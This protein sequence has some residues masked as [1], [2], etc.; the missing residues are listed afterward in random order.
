[1]PFLNYSGFDFQSRRFFFAYRQVYDDPNTVKTAANGGSRHDIYSVSTKYGT[2]QLIKKSSSTAG[3]TSSYQY[4]LSNHLNTFF[5]S[6]ALVCVL[7]AGTFCRPKNFLEKFR[8]IFG[9][10]S[11]RRIA[12]RKG[13]TTTNFQRGGENV[14]PNSRE[15]YKRCAFQ[16]YCNTVLHNEA[17]DAHKE[18]RRHKANVRCGTKQGRKQLMRILEEDKIGACSIEN[19]KLSDAKEWALRMKEKGYSFKTINNHK[20]SLKAAFYT[21]IQDDCI[22]KNPFDFQLNTVLEDNTEPNIGVQGVQTR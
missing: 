1:M 4:E 6:F 16:K 20:R 19:V 9:I 15:F 22:H 13:G 17:C 7:Q 12:P 14:E 10:F 21:A 11:K 18:L 2:F 5:N 3:D 8:K